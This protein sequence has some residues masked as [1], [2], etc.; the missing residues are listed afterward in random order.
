MDATAMLGKDFWTEA[1][2]DTCGT[3]LEVEYRRAMTERV[4]REFVHFYPAWK[5]WYTIRV[6]PI[7]DGGITIYFNDVTDQKLADV[8]L[9]KTV[10]DL[11][12][13]QAALERSS[14]AKDEFL[15]TLSHELRTPLTPVLL[16]AALL[17]ADERL[18]AEVR[19]QLAMIERN[20]ALEARL[21]DDMLDLTAVSR[22]KLQ[23]H[24]E[25]CDTHS[26]IG[27]AIA[28]VQEDARDKG[29]S[30]ERAFAA[31]HS[32][33]MADP[34]RFQQVIWNL[35]RNAVKFTPAGGR[36]FHSHHRKQSPLG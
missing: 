9:E 10:E 1:F 3:L 5:R 7:E 36:I 15:A 14:R 20:I 12:M 18:P 30:I 32:G 8:A 31:Q 33:L 19:T 13:T 22:G 21:I 11:K 23:F 17:R 26:L 24:A 25:L 27:L 4:A 16:T 34:A 28:I 35:L 6:Y 29:V 2:P